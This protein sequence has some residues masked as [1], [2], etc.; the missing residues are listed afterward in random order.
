MH[1]FLTPAQGLARS[2]RAVNAAYPL[3]VIHTG[4]LSETAMDA[5]VDDGCYL[6]ACKPFEPP[7]ENIQA[8]AI[9]VH[10]LNSPSCHIVMSNT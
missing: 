7:G 8:A 2:L 4:G 1:P 10:V 5:L 9:A 6:Y 3:I